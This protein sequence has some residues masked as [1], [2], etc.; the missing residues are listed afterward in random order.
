MINREPEPIIDNKPT[1][2]SPEHIAVTERTF[3]QYLARL[4]L[5]EQD[6]QGNSILDI[7][8]GFA[9]FVEHVNNAGGRAVGVDPVYSLFK[10]DFEDF[11]KVAERNRM[12][13]MFTYGG[14]VKDT[15]DQTDEEMRAAWTQF[16]NEFKEKA[17][18]SKGKYVAGSH[19]NLPF[20][21]ESMDLVVSNNSVTLLSDPLFLYKAM[22]E[23]RR[24]LKPD[25]EA[26][27]GPVPRGLGMEEDGGVY[28]SKPELD[29]NDDRTREALL[30]GEPIV[31]PSRYLVFLATEKA[32]VKF[33]LFDNG[34]EGEHPRP[35]IFAM[36]KDDQIPT[37]CR[38]YDQETTCVLK[39]YFSESR[40]I[41]HIPC[42]TVWEESA[43]AK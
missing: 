34:S 13:H 24:V 30:N 43:L 28:I 21:N 41:Y 38:D 15:P 1:T 40:D 19:Q 20:R 5:S 2:L 14:Q 35:L 17:I 12:H 3:E 18:N 36:R 22:Q 9:N 16:Y 11:E 42:E 29:P 26:R 37:V 8:S 4:S 10:D 32:G 33:Y 6:L 27:F 31:D 39:L 7:G 23:V 25:G